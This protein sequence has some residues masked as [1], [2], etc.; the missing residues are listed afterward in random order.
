M[1]T[2]A[3]T[4]SQA[5]SDPHPGLAGGPAHEAR[6]HL[7]DGG[8]TTLGFSGGPKSEELPSEQM[9][10]N[11]TK[12]EG[13]SSSSQTSLI[14]QDSAVVFTE[15]PSELVVP[16]SNL[17]FDPSP[18]SCL[19]VT[20]PPENHTAGEHASP[21]SWAPKSEPHQTQSRP[22]S[23]PSAD[24]LPTFTSQRPPDLPATTSKRALSNPRNVNN[25]CPYEQRYVT[26]SRA[27]TND[28]ILLISPTTNPLIATIN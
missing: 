3:P 26:Q 7:L 16:P 8:A 21:R 12:T 10:L 11:D 5:L 22:P 25:S 20:E 4:E 1:V 27:A 17:T 2:V 6:L 18:V 13:N 19:V 15:G 9:K 24:L 23:L 28:Y 14:L